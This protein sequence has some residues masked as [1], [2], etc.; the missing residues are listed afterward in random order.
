LLGLQPLSQALIYNSTGLLLEGFARVLQEF[1]RSLEIWPE[2]V[3][4][5]TLLSAF[6]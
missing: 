5:V 6:E 4:V 3:S 2:E 1:I